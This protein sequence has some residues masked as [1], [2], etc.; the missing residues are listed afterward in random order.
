MAHDIELLSVVLSMAV[1]WHY[2][3]VCFGLFS[4]EAITD[5]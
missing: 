2:A 5:C 4:P 1:T 3:G